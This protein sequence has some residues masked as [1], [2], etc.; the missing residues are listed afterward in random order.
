[1]LPMRTRVVKMS[2]LPAMLTSLEMVAS[3][4]LGVFLFVAG[5][6][7]LRGSFS[8]RRMHWIYVWV[9]IPLALVGGIAGWLTWKELFIAVGA[10]GRRSAPPGSFELGL[11]IM[12][13][14]GTLVV[15]IYPIALM[16]VLS[17]R[18][19][20]EYYT[21]VREDEAARKY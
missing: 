11:G 13:A 16:A 12:I 18:T 15:L 6:V 3:A 2:A 17:T 8:G 1:M 21:S 10:T 5:I 9:K 7:V 20:R 19:V 14:V 4:A